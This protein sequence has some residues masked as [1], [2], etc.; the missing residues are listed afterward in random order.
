M[1]LSV[2][3]SHAL[4]PSYG[5]SR[6]MR[7]LS[8]HVRT[9]ARRLHH[10]RT[11]DCL[12]RTSGGGSG[13]GSGV[14]GGSGDSSGGGSSALVSAA[15]VGITITGGFCSRYILAEG[16]ATAVPEGITDEVFDEDFGGGEED[17]D[18]QIFRDGPQ[19]LAAYLIAAKRVAVRGL[20]YV[21]YS[22]DIGESLRPVSTVLRSSTG[23]L[24]IG[25][26]Q[27]DRP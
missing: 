12:H 5:P 20:R 13:V 1:P 14:G 6:L 25:C 11:T 17:T 2:S 18:D 3:L 26:G 23:P 8:A 21:A 10:R 4:L 19:R 15:A 24:P 16:P 7:R 22:S 27:A 9:G